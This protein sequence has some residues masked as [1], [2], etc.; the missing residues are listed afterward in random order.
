MLTESTSY[1]KD[2]KKYWIEI[3]Y[4]ICVL[5]DY[6]QR[7]KSDLNFFFQSEEELCDTARRKQNLQRTMAEFDWKMSEEPY[8]CSV[9][10]HN[11]L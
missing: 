5:C 7:G 4:T 1:I 11:S 3:E 9:C 6:R 10:I 2:T 8:Q